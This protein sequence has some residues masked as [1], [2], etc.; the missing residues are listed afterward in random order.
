MHYRESVFVRL[1]FPSICHSPLVPFE[2]PAYIIT[3]ICFEDSETLTVFSILLESC[4]CGVITTAEQCQM[5]I[6]FQTPG[7][8][9]SSFGAK[10]EQILECSPNSA[11]LCSKQKLSDGFGGRRCKARETRP[12]GSFA[13][14]ATGSTLQRE[15]MLNILRRML[16]KHFTTLANSELAGAYT[17][18]SH[19][20]ELR[21]TQ[22]NSS[23][24]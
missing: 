17:V 15:R 23:L 5:P 9:T 19:L 22:G 18:N 24:N 3:T 12:A 6:G 11:T 21:V 7:Y 13:R 4:S 10:I 1:L 16:K 14:V 20:R 8:E 2:P